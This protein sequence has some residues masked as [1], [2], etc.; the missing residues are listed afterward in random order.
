MGPKSSDKCPHK[1]EAEGKFDTQ[2]CRQG[3]HRGRDWVNMATDE[4]MLTAPEPGKNEG[5]ILP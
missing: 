1:S 4:G 3:D 5:W 2:V